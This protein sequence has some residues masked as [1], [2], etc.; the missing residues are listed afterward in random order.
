MWTVRHKQD[1]IGLEG[2]LGARGRG[3]KY[4]AEKRRWV[5]IK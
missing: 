5:R 3:R 4:S 1:K 2:K